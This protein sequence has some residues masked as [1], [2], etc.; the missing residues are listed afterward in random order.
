MNNEDNLQNNLKD[1]ITEWYLLREQIGKEPTFGDKIQ[2]KENLEELRDDKIKEFEKLQ[3]DIKKYAE[4]LGVRFNEV[5]GEVEFDQ[6]NRSSKRAIA[7]DLDNEYDEIPPRTG[8]ELQ[9]GLSK[10]YNDTNSVNKALYGDNYGSSKA[11]EQSGGLVGDIAE[12]KNNLM[13]R[14]VSAKKLLAARVD[15]EAA[16]DNMDMAC[17]VHV[18]QK[19]VLMMQLEQKKI[20]LLKAISLGGNQ[21]NQ[22]IQGL[23]SDIAILTDRII[24]LEKGFENAYAMHAAR[25]NGAKKGL[26]NAA[27]E[28]EYERKDAGFQNKYVRNL[29]YSDEGV[30][31]GSNVNG[32][33][34]GNTINEQELYDERGVMICDVAD[35]ISRNTS[36]N[37]NGI[38]V[39]CVTEFAGHD[40][41]DSFYVGDMEALEVNSNGS[42][43]VIQEKPDVSEEELAEEYV[44]PLDIKRYE[45]ANKMLQRVKIAGVAYAA[46]QLG[47]VPENL[48]NDAGKGLKMLGYGTDAFNH[49]ISASGGLCEK[50]AG[51]VLEYNRERQDGQEIAFGPRNNTN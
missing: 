50:I 21:S 49:S 42:D 20:D 28:V 25:F 46:E 40:V 27:K 5:T 29:S 22:E 3:N 37:I 10:V 6:E 33:R 16:K 47:L 35:V 4:Y 18:A 14:D 51:K 24:G 43:V 8:D 34:G 9:E 31:N 19:Y 23:K 17:A 38:V 1:K 11:L 45:P 13:K 30:L 39:E 41:E 12:K 7:G 2:R 15:L 36:I 32:V 48:R 44:E 26:E